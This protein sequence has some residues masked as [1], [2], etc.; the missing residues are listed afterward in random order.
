MWDVEWPC[1]TRI[2][3]P[4]MPQIDT[5]AMRGDILKNTRLGEAPLTVG[6]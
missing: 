3:L 1:G 5:D 6:K 2:F 4:Q